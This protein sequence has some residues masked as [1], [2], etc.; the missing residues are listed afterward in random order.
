MK[1]R[2]IVAIIGLCMMT[3][4]TACGITS[5]NTNSNV[6][7][8]AGED[9]YFSTPVEGMD[10]IT[11]N[12]CKFKAMMTVGEL[13]QAINGDITFDGKNMDS[14]DTIIEADGYKSY[15][16]LGDSSFSIDVYNDSTEAVALRDCK[17]LGFNTRY[18]YFENNVEYMGLPKGCS[19]S[20]LEKILGPTDEDDPVWYYKNGF[21]ISVYVDD[22][23]NIEGINIY[24]DVN[25][26]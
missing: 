2:I 11:I 16:I 26:L 6:S 13:T 12:G 25:D 1:K 17:V 14:L 22:E 10:E 20:E 15:D 4:F 8:D 9:D 18:F 3:T 19:L 5:S 7:A 21:L 24:Y 23:K